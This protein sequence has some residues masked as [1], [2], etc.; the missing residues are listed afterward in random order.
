MPNNLIQEIS[1][2]KVNAQN[3]QAI[4]T[5]KLVFGIII[6]NIR[7]I[8]RNG[9][10]KITYPSKKRKDG[11]FVEYVSLV[12]VDLKTAIENEIWRRYR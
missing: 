12:D 9:T 8:N 11:E 10:L 1:I 2:K 3:T 4:V 6:R 7:V 5:V